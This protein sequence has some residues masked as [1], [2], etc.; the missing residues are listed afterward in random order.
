[1]AED[2]DLQDFLFVAPSMLKGAGAGLFLD[3]VGA[4]GHLKG[5]TR[6]II[7]GFYGLIRQHPTQTESAYGWTGTQLYNV[8]V[9]I[10]ENHD[11]HAMRA[12]CG[13]SV[14][15]KKPGVLPSLGRTMI[16]L[17][18]PSI[19]NC[20]RHLLAIKNYDPPETPLLTLLACGERFV[21][22]GNPTFCMNSPVFFFLD[23]TVTASEKELF[24]EVR[25]TEK[26][27]HAVYEYGPYE[28]IYHNVIAIQ[29]LR[30][31]A[32]KQKGVTVVELVYAYTNST[33]SSCQK[34]IPGTAIE[35]T[36]FYR[37]W[38]NCTQ[39]E[40][41]APES[42]V[43]APYRLKAVPMCPRSRREQYLN[44]ASMFWSTLHTVEDPI[45][46]LTSVS[47]DNGDTFIE[48]KRNIESLP[49]TPTRGL[50][51]LVDAHDDLGIRGDRCATW[52]IKMVRTRMVRDVWILLN[53]MPLETYPEG[54]MHLGIANDSIY[55][56]FD[57]NT[58]EQIKRL[59]AYW[60]GYFM[61]QQKDIKMDWEFTIHIQNMD[62][63]GAVIPPRQEG[64]ADFVYLCIDEDWFY[65]W[66]E[67][68]RVVVNIIGSDA[69]WELKSALSRMP[70]DS[71]KRTEHIAQHYA[72]LLTGLSKK[73]KT[74]PKKTLVDLVGWG[75]LQPASKNFCRDRVK[76]LG[77]DLRR[78]LD[79]CPRPNCVNMCTSVK[80]WIPEGMSRVV[81]YAT[82]QTVFAK[83]R[84][85]I[86]LL[87]LQYPSPLTG[88]NGRRSSPV[89][90]KACLLET[91]ASAY[92]H[93]PDF[94]VVVYTNECVDDPFYRGL[95]ARHPNVGVETIGADEHSFVGD[96]THC[97]TGDC[98]FQK[99]AR[100]MPLF[101]SNI[102][103]VVIWDVDNK[104]TDKTRAAHDAWL[105]SNDVA[106]TSRYINKHGGICCA[107]NFGIKLRGTPLCPLP[108]IPHHTYHT[109]C[110]DET[111]LEQVLT[112][113][114]VTPSVWNVNTMG[115]VVK[116]DA[117]ALEREIN[118]FV[119]LQSITPIDIGHHDEKTTVYY[120]LFLDK[121]S[122][123]IGTGVFAYDKIGA[124]SIIG[125]FQMDLVAVE[126]VTPLQI[127]YYF[128]LD[129]LMPGKAL[130]PHTTLR[131]T[132]F[133]DKN[134]W[135]VSDIPQIINHA[136]GKR[137]EALTE[138]VRFEFAWPTGMITLYSKIAIN[139]GD[140]LCY[141]YENFNP[142]MS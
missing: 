108:V 69:M 131:A 33:A 3:V 84:R 127:P 15:P 133:V 132:G 36:D 129:N 125:D 17:D 70:Y 134:E 136:Y 141:V 119:R 49:F 124:G 60:A 39:F 22:A 107:G 74:L 34:K 105:A 79:T 56:S 61:E 140:E 31:Q 130:V 85:R 2:V 128:S 78:I 64:G 142:A 73:M 38:V 53:E 94:G 16:P 52:V 65:T 10:F 48:F 95:E 20:V 118:T 24:M 8:V 54:V 80:K 51:L 59:K 114:R 86:V 123:D 46:P 121:V 98:Q 35:Q 12:E 13:R 111:F 32:F 26:R 29:P 27:G 47:V 7:P 58:P 42:P 100:F 99:L 6:G 77:V 115:D 28:T 30:L 89:Y 68:H 109:Y 5:A 67:L 93:Y 9:P 88:C 135:F 116:D 41:C 101:Q 75:L 91:L 120:R 18:R 43:A 1:M 25:P 83:S 72:Q 137:S 82:C 113:N 102:D 63:P 138:N 76:T 103:V 14:E 97:D 87:C 117:P 44:Y 110:D 40:N 66:D 45:Y 62:Q 71:D 126:K 11:L 23:H 81:H 122:D 90:Y 92:R 112:H 106:Y 4:L 104:L 37:R 139:A 50:L 21:A 55:P 19:D 57:R 96:F